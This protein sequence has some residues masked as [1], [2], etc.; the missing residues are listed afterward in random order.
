[1]H[2]S[3]RTV[4]RFCLAL[5]AASASAADSLLIFTRT[6]GVRENN[7]SDTRSAL[8]AFYET[9]GLA[10]DL[11]ENGA[12]ISDTGLAH[13]RA[14]VFLKTTG[15][16]LNDAQQAAFEKWFQAG[17]AVQIIHAALDAETN[18]PFYGKL[19]GGAWFKSLPG[20]STTRHTIVVEDTADRA[21]RDLP[22]RWERTDEIYGFRSNPRAAR[23]PQMHI[24]ATVDGRGRS[25]HELVLRLPGRPRLDHGHGACHRRLSRLPVPGASLGRYAVSSRCSRGG[26]AGFVPSLSR[27]GRAWPRES[28]LGP[29]LRAGIGSGRPRTGCRRCPVPEPLTPGRLKTGLLKRGSWPIAARP[30]HYQQTRDDR[31]EAAGMDTRAAGGPTG[32]G[33]FPM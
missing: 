15:D 24:L 33:S 5:A 6:A 13:Y 20:D 3:F 18:W 11:S 22:R 8:K 9:K 17:G 14:I 16:F 30:T 26:L 1:M 4:F 12:Q 31:R 29:R 23:D 10:V 28:G 2:T 27:P 25:S 7:I 21:D 32:T 19:I